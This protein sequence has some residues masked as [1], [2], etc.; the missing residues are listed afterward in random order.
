MVTLAINSTFSHLNG[1]DLHTKEGSISSRER[2]AVVDITFASN[3]TYPTNGKVLDFSKIK[4][5]R[6]V[7]YCKILTKSFANEATFIP[8]S[9][10]D[11]ATGKLKV[12]DF[13]GVELSNG[14]TALESQTMTV[15]IRG[16]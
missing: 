6:Q 8:A 15:E 1:V 13:S 11:A 2:H 16:I 10:N 5:F 14:N 3:D 9:G 4:Q 7:Y 12:F